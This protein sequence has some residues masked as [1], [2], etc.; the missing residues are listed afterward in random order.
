MGFPPHAAAASSHVQSAEWPVPVGNDGVARHQGCGDL[1]REYRERKIPR[2]DAGKR[3]APA[4]TGDSAPRPGRR[5]PGA[6]RTAR[7]RAPHSNGRNPPPHAARR[8]HPAGSCRPRAPAGGGRRRAG[9]SNRS[10]AF[11]RQAAPLS[12]RRRVPSALGPRAARHRA[13]DLRLGRIPRETHD[14]R[15]G[16][17]ERTGTP[18]SIASPGSR[19][20]RPGKQVPAACSSSLCSAAISA[21]LPSPRHGSCAARAKSAS[22]SRIREGLRRRAASL[23]CLAHDLLHR[24]IFVEEMVHERSVGAVLEQPAHEVGQ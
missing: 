19:W 21:G 15:R 20:V 14:F 4:T 12:G 17:G 16:A 22:G 10:A 23:N 1:S 5:A 7:G 3:P 6:R 9:S 24:N 18:A 11:S 8:S 2:A 13:G